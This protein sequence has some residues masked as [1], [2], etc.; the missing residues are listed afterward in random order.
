MNLKTTAKR[1][2]RIF[3]NISHPARLRI[4]LAI[5][6]GEACVC[7]L[8][9]LLGYRQAYIS[10]HMMALRKAGLLN[11]RRDGRYIFYQ[12][13]DTRLLALLR[14]AASL[15]GIAEDELASDADRGPLTNC[16]CPKCTPA[17]TA[18]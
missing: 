8:E 10:Q 6:E 13:R 17:L 5:G 3:S 9:N 16:G 15:A 12:L 2:S 4:L 14:M 18:Q 11:S 7:H 1:I